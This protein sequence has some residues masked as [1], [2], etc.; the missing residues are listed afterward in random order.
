MTGLQHAR[1]Q[2]EQQIEQPNGVTPLIGEWYTDR[3]GDRV[4]GEFWS[5]CAPVGG[6][7]DTLWLVAD[8]GGFVA[9]GQRKGS[10]ADSHYV[11]VALNGY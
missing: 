11:Q 7:R 10:P 9:V 5:R 1:K 2:I 6:Y 4:F 8:G 3:S